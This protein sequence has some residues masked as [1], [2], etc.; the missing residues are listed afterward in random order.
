MWT[1]FITNKKLKKENKNNLKCIFFWVKFSRSNKFKVISSSNAVDCI[2][3]MSCVTAGSIKHCFKGNT[4]NRHW[5]ILPLPTSI[6]SW[7]WMVYL[8]TSRCC[9]YN[10]QWYC[11]S[12]F[13]VSNILDLKNSMLKLEGKTRFGISS[14]Q[15]FEDFQKHFWIF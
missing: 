3:Y 6:S 2:W 7:R 11:F 1:E 15:L 4:L 9:N 12:V 14:F 8:E 13:H 5:S 10:M